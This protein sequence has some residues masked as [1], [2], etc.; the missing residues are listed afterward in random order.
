MLDVSFIQSTNTTSQTFYAQSGS[1]SWQTW[2]KPRNAKMVRILCVGSGGGGGGGANR[3]LTSGIASGGNG[4]ASGG[5]TSG[6]FAAFL[7]PD[8]L[9]VQPGLGGEGG[10]GS[11]LGPGG[12]GDGS[13]GR[14]G[15]ISV[16]SVSPTASIQSAITYAVA[17]RGGGGGRVSLNCQGA[18]STPATASVFQRLGI[19]D[20][21]ATE[22][23]QDI[24]VAT[25][26]TRSAFDTT[27]SICVMQ[28]VVGGS[29]Y[30]TATLYNGSS[31]A[32]KSILTGSLIKGGLS[33][34]GAPNGA[35]KS[36]IGSSSPFFYG[37]G[38]AG[39]GANSLQS[40]GGGFYGCG[41]G[42]GGAAYNTGGTG[43]KGGD[44]LVIITTLY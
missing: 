43:G 22:A 20:A 41:G 10:L 24:L 2:V 33:G 29:R 35:G 26:V 21:S 13:S 17:G 15:K 18:D 19:V 5:I 44:G 31:I 27:S 4:G 14:T 28:G 40:G 8:I 34:T 12:D 16:V 38:G 30:P 37:T 11:N 7:L 23:S 3:A 1:D 42:G 32:G 25:P 9:Y 6:L 39:S 36:G